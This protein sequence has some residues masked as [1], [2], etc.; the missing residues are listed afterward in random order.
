MPVGSTYSKQTVTIS[1]SSSSSQAS[2]KG[3]PMTCP[4]VQQSDLSIS[5]ENYT[6]E[7][8]ISKESTLQISVFV[9]YSRQTPF[10]NASLPVDSISLV[11]TGAGGQAAV[12]PSSQH[13][14]S[15]TLSSRNNG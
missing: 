13:S 1:G 2:A 5:S 9:F 8:E 4:M 7:L 11:Q 15:S 3:P 10:S 12:I 6:I 14:L